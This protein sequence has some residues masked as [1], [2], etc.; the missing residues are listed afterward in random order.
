MTILVSPD[1]FKGSL[2][3]WEATD[4]IS[5][6]VK[7]VF[8][9]AEVIAL[10]IADGGEGT[11]NALVFASNGK[12]LESEVSGPLPHQKVKAIWG[13]L[14]DGETAVI[15]MAAAA[16]ITLVPPEKRDPKITTTY[17]VGEL[18]C[19]ALDY[20]A[21][22]IIVGLGGSATN[23][24]GAGMAQALG[25]RLLDKNGRELHRGGAT[26][27]HLARI[28]VSNIDRRIHGVEII[29]ATDVI[30]TLCGLSGAS[31]VYAP[32]KGA[33]PQDVE[34]LDKAL[35]HYAKIIQRD[36]GIDVLSL[37]RGGAAGGLGAGIAAFCNAKL[38]NGIDIVLD[39]LQFDEK[40]NRAN[41]VITGEGKIDAQT[42]HGKAIKGIT[43]RVWQKSIPVI[44]IAGMID[45]DN[46]QLQK[47]LHLS[48]IFS[49]MSAVITKEE[50]M[51]RAK[52]LVYQRTLEALSTLNLTSK[53][54]P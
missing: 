15:E 18:I 17:G 11:V 22:K 13:L 31:F 54:S 37:P 9:S 12:L 51:R 6:A 33:T 53:P 32:Q 35:Q 2:T 14:G 23:D 16:G 39:T 45:G 43:E 40:L 30:N 25:V 20:C 21:K 48:G 28:D 26:L 47:E 4:A 24:G 27:S 10:P 8:P 44:A 19:V 52:E 50:A 34:L 7:T 1:S 5:R 41:L 42:K 36:L 38:K 29:G 3:A 49:L 46:E